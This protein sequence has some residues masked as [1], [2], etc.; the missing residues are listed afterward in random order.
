[1]LPFVPLV[2]IIVAA[3][4][5]GQVEVDLEDKV[6]FFPLRVKFNEC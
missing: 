6:Q 1:M 2:D 4:A 3:D 5:R